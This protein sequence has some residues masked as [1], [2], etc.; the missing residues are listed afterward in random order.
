MSS[1]CPADEPNNWGG[2]VPGE[3]CA[4]AHLWK[5][6]FKWYDAACD[7][8]GFAL[9]LGSGF[10]MNP[11]CEHKPFATEV[12]EVRV[13]GREQEN[14]GALWVAHMPIACGLP[15]VPSGRQS[16]NFK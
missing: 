3:D 16:C 7:I 2:K 8:R 13:E 14:Q 6:D 1:F 15:E 5:K 10:T 12:A 9:Q 11:L 4:I